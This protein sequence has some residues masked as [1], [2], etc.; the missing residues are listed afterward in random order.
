M[1]TILQNNPWAKT[2]DAD[3]FYLP[4]KTRH[5]S[6]CICPMP[7]AIPYASTM[8]QMQ[9]CSIPRTGN[10][11]LGHRHRP[12]RIR[13]IPSA[14]RMTEGRCSLAATYTANPV[15]QMPFEP[16]S[17]NPNFCNLLTDAPSGIRIGKIPY[18]CIYF[19]YLL[20]VYPE[21]TQTPIAGVRRLSRIPDRV[22]LVP[23]GRTG[24][25]QQLDQY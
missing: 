1:V 4:A 17:L 24:G 15:R 5:A 9:Q 20:K 6:A 16:A 3:S 25:K 22:K 14:Y 12:G 11:C 2:A 8:K 13:G 19:L 18:R 21:A 7:E 10:R 23:S